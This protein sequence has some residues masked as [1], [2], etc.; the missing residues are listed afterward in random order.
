MPKYW[1]KLYFSHGSF[2]KICLWTLIYFSHVF[3]SKIY[4]IR[5]LIFSLTFCLNHLSLISD[6]TK[7]LLHYKTK[8]ILKHYSPLIE[9]FWCLRQTPYFASLTLLDLIKKTRKQAWARS[10]KTFYFSFYLILFLLPYTF[11]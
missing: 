8:T 1:G 3:L 4:T 2:L 11:P 9:R 6:I 7:Y 5:Y 10:A